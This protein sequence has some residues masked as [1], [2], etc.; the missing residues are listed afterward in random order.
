ML[1]N[2]TEQVPSSNGETK[3]ESDKQVNAPFTESGCC[4]EK[5]SRAGGW[6]VFAACGGRVAFKYRMTEE[7]LLNHRDRS[8]GDLKK[9]NLPGMSVGG[10]CSSSGEPPA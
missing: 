6:G 7:G 9:V 4:G 10:G 2:E 8:G 3:Q 5:Q 1:V